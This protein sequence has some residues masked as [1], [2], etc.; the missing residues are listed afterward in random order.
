MSKYESDVKALQQELRNERRENKRDSEIAAKLLKREA[1]L[2]KTIHNLR[3]HIYGLFVELKD[4]H[5]EVCF[6]PDCDG[7]CCESKHPFRAEEKPWEP[8][9]PWETPQ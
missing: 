8:H 6:D 9:Y 4:A 7:I 1:E 3:G 2:L 5:P